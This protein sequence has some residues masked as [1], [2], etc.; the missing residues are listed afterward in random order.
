MCAAKPVKPAKGR[1]GKKLAA[2]R[3]KPV[4]S[5]GG[6]DATRDTAPKQ[7][8]LRR[9]AKRGALAIV[10]CLV[11]SV[12]W[13]LLYR[14][15]NPPF[16]LLMVQR[17]L[18]AEP[19]NARIKKAWVA[20]EEMAPEMVLAVLASEDQRYFSHG[21][22]D[23]KEIQKAYTESQEGERL[24]GASTITQ[25]TAKNVFLWNSRS[26]V[27]KGL[28]V[29]FTGLIEVLWGKERILEVYLNVLETGHGL[30]GVEAAGQEF[31]QRP[32]AKLSASQCALIAA[33]LPNPL[34]RSPAAPSAY[35][36]ERQ[37][38][39]LGQMRNLG[40]R[41]FLEENGLFVPARE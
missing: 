27:R 21:G 12:A 33:V 41:K 26:W 7:G 24:R 25:Q 13:V 2:R 37:Q 23:V 6:Q 30:Y 38:W 31:F 35:V 1:G 28:E 20:L 8:W 29:Y 18:S 34:D 15:V 22:V 32:A 17:Y 14:F 3:P 4:P 40:G 5:V 11:L 19:E 10:A 39:I 36:R 16:T 9:W